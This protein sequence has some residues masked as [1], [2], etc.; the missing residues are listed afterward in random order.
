MNDSKIIIIDLIMKS[1][2]RKIKPM[3]YRRTKRG[4]LGLFDTAASTFNNVRIR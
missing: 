2:S 1:K 3:H 4:G